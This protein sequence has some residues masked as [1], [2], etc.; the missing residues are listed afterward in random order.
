MKK[1]MIMI[2]KNFDSRMG[3]LLLLLF[4]AL[5]SCNK[6][7]NPTAKLE[8]RLTDA[9]GDYQEVNIDIQDVQVNVEDGSPS[10]GWKSLTVKKGVYN[11]MKLTKGLDTLLGDA[12]LPVGKVSQ[13]RLVLGSNNSI[14]VAG[15]ILLLTTPS[16]QQSGLKVQIH[17]DLKEGITYKILLDF[18]A[19]RSIVATGNGKFI[20][21]PVIR[22]VVEALSGSIKGLI[23]PV[24]SKPAVY[25]L[26]G[27][28]TVATTF[29]D[30]VSGK[31]LLKG[32]AAG[33]FTVSFAPK[34]GYLPT[35]KGNVSVTIGNVTD[36]GTVQ[37]AQ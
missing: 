29:A 18:D 10:S 5:V 1:T 37:I 30:S 22:S 35:T 15:Q 26:S 27:V 23:S 7:N 36:L 24:A 17:T 12:Q 34:T 25:A 11:L 4:V 16:A 32:V 14:K 13:L 9:P 21:K 19:A 20:L 28:D 6:D 33:T 3:W 2:R 8:V 31:F